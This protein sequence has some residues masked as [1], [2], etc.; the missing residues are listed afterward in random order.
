MIR[1]FKRK[2]ILSKEQSNRI[3]SWIGACRVVY[4]LGMEIKNKAY[5][6]K[7]LSV[8][9]Y[10][11]MK[12]LPDLKKDLAWIK[13]VPSQSLQAALDRLETSYQ[14][15][16]R[17]HKK[18]AGYPRF[19]SKR[20]YRSI[21]FKTVTVDEDLVT[22]P[23]IGSLRM[24]KDS[25]ILGTPKTATIIKEPTGYFICIQCE[26]VPQ[27][28]NSE[29]QTIGLDMGIA[30][31]CVDS[32]GH[33]IENPKHFKKY[34][35]QLRIENRSLVRKK[36]GSASWKKQAQKLVRLHHKIACVR[37]DFLHKESTRIAKENSVV[38]M[39]DLNVAGMSRN[40]HLSKHILDCGW[41]MFRTMLS[42]KTTVITVSAAYTSQTCNNCGHTDKASRIN[43]ADFECTL[44]GH[45]ENADVNAAK[46][47]KRK[48]I[49]QERQR[50]AVA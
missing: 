11:L 7:R 33:Y 41:S 19:A 37:K 3:D 34:E 13:D 1:T 12:Q 50:K 39:E 49:P 28:F 16:F 44:C 26:N 21:L 48:G 31:F 5:R 27:K 18:G 24:F 4:N 2:L 6:D 8:S 20:K 29:N 43:Q 9:K 30:R 17:N 14:N 25:S 10:D 15:F 45:K 23:K 36:K 35:S 47:I 42:Y 38:Y 32:N 46:N 40:G 22:L